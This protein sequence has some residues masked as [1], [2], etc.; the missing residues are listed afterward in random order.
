MNDVK[1]KHR[2]PDVD[3]EKEAQRMAAMLG[4][5]QKRVSKNPT[6]PEKLK[7]DKQRRRTKSK[8]QKHSRKANNRK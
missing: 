2:N 8:H 6:A 1:I 5:L 4:D 7:K 3:P